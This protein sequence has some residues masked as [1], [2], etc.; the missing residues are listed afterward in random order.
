MC[1]EKDPAHCHRSYVVGATVAKD[2]AFV[3]MH[4]DKAGKLKSHAEL[5]PE[6]KPRQLDMLF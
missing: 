5:K 6:I 2:V 1:S 4:V 3:V